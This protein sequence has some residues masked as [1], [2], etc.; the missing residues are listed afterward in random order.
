VNM[1]GFSK[2]PDITASGV[3][4][5]ILCQCLVISSDVSACS[6]GSAFPVVHAIAA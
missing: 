5:R 6:A 1:M 3:R 2:V 4:E